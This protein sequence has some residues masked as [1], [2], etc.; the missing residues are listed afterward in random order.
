MEMN[1]PFHRK[2]RPK[3]LSEYIGNDKLKKSVLSALR[4]SVLPQVI[5][6]KGHAGCGKTT[7]ARLIAKEYLCENRDKLTGACGECYSC[8][9]L[10]D[11]IEKGDTGVVYNVR[12]VDATDNNKKEHVE[13]LIEEASIPSYDGSWKVYIFDECHM[14][15]QSAQNR[16]L[17]HLEEPP[18]KVLTILCTTDP[19][20][21]LE[22][23]VSRCQYNFT[24]SKPTREEL[25]PL[26]TRV[27]KQEGVDYDT[28]GLS[29]VCV[30]GDFVPR[31]TLIALEQVI[32]EK[33]DVTYENV[34]D[35][36]SLV[37]DKVFFEFYKLLTK[38]PLD[39]F[40]YVAFLGDLKLKYDLKV[41]VDN[42]INFTIRGLYV[43]SGVNVDALDESEVRSY[44]QLFAKWSPL[45][46]SNLLGYLLD[47]KSSYN[48]IESK[49]LLLGYELLNKEMK[50]VLLPQNE[51]KEVTSKIDVS[52][53]KQ[54][55]NKH[56]D[57][58]V[59]MTEEDL[60]NY[61]SSKKKAVSLDDLTNLFSSVKVVN[62]KN[63]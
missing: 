15:T 45:E 55:S 9:Q 3:N 23:I 38:R 34:V 20:K 29:L 50:T 37:S 4:S 59:K 22:T 36:L 63:E 24:V 6:L 32:R 41:F 53:E 16:L 27:C 18:E 43:L 40:S 1:L 56:Y 35:V 44:K 26:L 5:L 28:K 14:I 19:Q 58:R 10:D 8:K 39:I 54:V 46:I 47:I 11:Y 61:I 51:Q 60:T 31:K 7:M 52:K 13:Q 33:G 12:E 49:L 17:K 30:K 42:L 21:L 57:E 62:M 25:I 48:D 2:Y